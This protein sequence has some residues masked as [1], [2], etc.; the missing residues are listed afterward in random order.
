MYSPRFEVRRNCVVGRHNPLVGVSMFTVVIQKDLVFFK[1][2]TVM[3]ET[4]LGRLRET[5]EGAAVLVVFVPIVL[6]GVSLALV[7]A[8]REK[9]D[10]ASA[11]FRVFEA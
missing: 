4:F 8:D 7:L 6:V 9:M 10:S 1:V 2:F 3:L 11:I 5:L